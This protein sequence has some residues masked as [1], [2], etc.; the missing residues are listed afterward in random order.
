MRDQE[1]AVQHQ[2]KGLPFGYKVA[3]VRLELSMKR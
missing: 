1:R 3:I 2:D